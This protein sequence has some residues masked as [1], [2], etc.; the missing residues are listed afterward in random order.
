MEIAAN[1]IDSV[2]CASLQ[3][4]ALRV[5]LAA[6]WVVHELLVACESRQLSADTSIVTQEVQDGTAAGVCTRQEGVKWT[7]ILG[8]GA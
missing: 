1:A 2:Y 7:P 3:V 8:P 4:G 5:S 6:R